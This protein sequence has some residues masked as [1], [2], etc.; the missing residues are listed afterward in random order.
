VAFGADINRG[1]QQ[2]T[3]FVG[4]DTSVA[5]DPGKGAAL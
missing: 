3:E 1:S 5:Q 2:A 4:V